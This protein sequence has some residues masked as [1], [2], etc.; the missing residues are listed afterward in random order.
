MAALTG[1]TG[2]RSPFGP[3]RIGFLRDMSPRIRTTRDMGQPQM[4]PPWS[5]P[6]RRS[7]L[8]D[9]RTGANGYS[10]ELPETNVLIDHMTGAVLR[11][12]MFFE[13]KTRLFPLYHHSEP[14][15]VVINKTRGRFIINSRP[16][17]HVVD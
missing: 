16:M 3:V 15:I 1:E 9:Q 2:R 5:R 8:M 10:T 4:D 12:M 17:L 6:R 13:F 14:G 11:C 7:K